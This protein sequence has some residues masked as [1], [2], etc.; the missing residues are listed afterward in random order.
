MLVLFL[1]MAHPDYTLTNSVTHSVPL[2]LHSLSLPPSSC[3]ARLLT[4]PQQLPILIASIART[5]F[6]SLWPT[7][8]DE[9]VRTTLPN[10]LRVLREIVAMLISQRLPAQVC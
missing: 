9:A 6:P 4:F 5:D 10:R 2:S 8:L 1:L 3:S 7:L